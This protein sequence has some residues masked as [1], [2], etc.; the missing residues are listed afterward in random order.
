[1]K[2]ERKREVIEMVRR[3]PVAKKETL[4]EL[5]LAASTYYR[6]QRRY[7]REGAVGLVDRRPQ[8]VTIW[9]RLRP[10]EEQTILRTALAAP[11]HSP[12]EIACWISDHAGFTISESS[13]YRV[14]KRHG[15]VREVQLE[16]F[17][18]GPEYRIQTTRVNE[19]WQS[20][21]SY[22]FVG[23]GWYYLISAL[24]DFSRFLLAWEL[25][26]D[27]R[28]AFIREVV[29]RAV[30]F[31]GMKNVPV[32]DRTR[33]LS[34][35]GSSYLSQAFEDYLRMRQ[36]RHLRCAPHHPQTNG[37]IERFHET[38]KARLN[39]LVYTSPE[40]LRR[41]LA[42]FI[43]F[44]NQRRYHEGIG[45]VTPADVYYGRREEILR[46][47]EVQKQRTLQERFRY[48]LGQRSDRATGESEAENRSLS[49]GLTSSQRR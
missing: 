30:E 41:A 19:Q 15:L 8:P 6:W 2:P 20:D 49:D 14:L 11:D 22:F 16:G 3:S 10:E 31:T 12:R 34:D 39:L 37:K 23:W 45:N 44:Y 33:L 13:V 1:M 43:E 9:N 17:P 47:R 40:E 48:N 28:S 38:L 32:E 18:A 27:M 4:A 46:R 5:G 29:E 26:T 35:N 21:A 42:E 25:K 36:I 7:R 24:D